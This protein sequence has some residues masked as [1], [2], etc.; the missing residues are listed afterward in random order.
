MRVRMMKPVY[1]R[2]QDAEGHTVA[3]GTPGAVK[4]K[5]EADKWYAEYYVGR[6]KKKVPLAKDKSVAQ[7]MLAAL[8]RE[9]EKG[10]VGLTDPYK[11]HRHLPLSEHVTEYLK[12]LERAVKDGEMSQKH[13]SERRRVLKTVLVGVKGEVA[14][15]EPERDKV[16]ERMTLADISS[17]SLS[18]FLKELGTSPR[19]RDTYRGAAVTFC[20][21]LVS[22]D[23]GKRLEH[24][25]LH[26]VS[27]QKGRTVRDA[28]GTD[29]Q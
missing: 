29:A 3:K 15:T 18:R 28:A 14:K 26:E 20:N 4:V 10:Q 25:P 24:N 9:I 22:V 2:Y 1:T 16:L 5:A 6:K 23:G 17:V 8:V 7:V 27:V 11:K 12:T 21:W 19:T 13:Y